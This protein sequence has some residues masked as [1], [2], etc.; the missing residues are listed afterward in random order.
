[1]PLSDLPPPPRNSYTGDYDLHDMFGEGGR[2]VRGESKTDKKLRRKLNQAIG[3]GPVGKKHNMIRHGAQ[4]DYSKYVDRQN[5]K[6]EKYN[7]KNPKNPKK[8]IKKIPSLTQPDP[9]LL[10]F[11]ENGKIYELKNKKDV[12]DYYACKGEEPNP[13]WG[14]NK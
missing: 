1:M 5:A 7:K 14:C 4:S 13:E 11:D 2:R 6:I 8:P 10:A 9:P 12:C 3:R